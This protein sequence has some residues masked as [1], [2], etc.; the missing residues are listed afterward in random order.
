MHHLLEEIPEPTRI[1][2]ALV[3][4]WQRDGTAPFDLT[5]H[6]VFWVRNIWLQ[7]F[8]LEFG[9]ITEGA[10]ALK[11]I[12]RNWSAVPVHLPVEPC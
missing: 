9:S 12:Q 4:A 3:S 7:P 2:G 10:R 6:P 1:D 8:L 5:V 11:K